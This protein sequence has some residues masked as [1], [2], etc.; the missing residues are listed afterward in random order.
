MIFG[1]KE[2]PH[3]LVI[4]ANH[5]EVAPIRLVGFT[6]VPVLQLPNGHAFPKANKLLE[7]LVPM[8]YSNQSVNE[9]LS[10]DEISFQSVNENLSYDNII[11]FGHLRGLTLARDLKWP[12]KLREYIGYMS[13]KADIPLLDSMAVY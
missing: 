9:N 2:I 10:Y 6:Q 8:F 11:F 7:R 3:E 5:D 4:L 12:T 1:F 13:D